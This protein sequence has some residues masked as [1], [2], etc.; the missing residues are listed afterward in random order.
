MNGS[1]AET[2]VKRTE[3]NL[4]MGT[5]LDFARVPSQAGMIVT[6]ISRVQMWRHDPKALAILA[7]PLLAKVLALG[8][9]WRVGNHI[10]VVGYDPV[11]IAQR[12]PVLQGGLVRPG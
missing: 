1:D 9:H 12:G 5:L 11:E 7:V 8:G 6:T 10:E 4:E 2:V 3:K